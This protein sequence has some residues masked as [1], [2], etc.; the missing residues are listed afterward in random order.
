MPARNYFHHRHEIP[1][2]TGFKLGFYGCLGIIAA[3]VFVIVLIFVIG[4]GACAIVIPDLLPKPPIPVSAE[5]LCHA[6]KDDYE[7]KEL[8]VSGIVAEEV[9]HGFKRSCVYLSGGQ[10]LGVMCYFEKEDAH[11]L[12][13]VS[14][15]DR[16]SVVGVC[17]GKNDSGIVSLLECRLKEVSAVKADQEPSN[18]SKSVREHQTPRSVGATRVTSPTCKPKSTGG[19]QTRRNARI[20]SASSTCVTV[21]A[22]E[23]YKAYVD[24]E[25]RADAKYKGKVLQVSGVVTEIE[26]GVSRKPYVCLSG[27]EG[28]LFGVKCFFRKENARVLSR[29]SKGDYVT[30]IGICGGRPV[31]G[32]V[33]LEKCKIGGF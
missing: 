19:N 33:F 6:Y 22:E 27:G 29:L 2:S 31:L 13:R 17:L 9:I 14:K 11:A 4:G 32:N 5:E 12:S 1:R 28:R 16:V 7:G 20:P 25:K 15:G 24:D 10:G 3:I 8:Q 30:I 26:R 23:L 21:S 18:T